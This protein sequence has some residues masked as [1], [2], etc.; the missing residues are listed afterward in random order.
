MSNREIYAQ[1]TFENQATGS[2]FYKEGKLNDPYLGNVNGIFQSWKYS[3]DAGKQVF[4]ATDSDKVYEKRLIKD[5][6]GNPHWGTWVEICPGEANGIQAISINNQPLLLPNEDGAIKLQ[7]TPQMIDTYTKREIYDL[8]NSKVEEIETDAYIYVAWKDGCETPK[9]VLE[10]TFPEGGELSKFYLVDPKPEEGVANSATYFI[11]TEN[12][13]WKEADIPNMGAFVSYSAFIEHAQDKIIHVSAEDREKWDSLA[14]AVAKAIE[15]INAAKDEF[16]LHVNNINNSDSPHITVEERQKLLTAYEN[17]KDMPEED[18]RF[19]I[20]NKQYVRDYIQYDLDPTVKSELLKEINSKTFNDGGAL[21]LL[22][23]NFRTKYNTLSTQ[24]KCIKNLRVELS[25]IMASAGM[26]WHLDANNGWVSDQYTNANT[27]TIIEIPNDKLPE[28]LNIKLSNKEASVTVTNIKI[29]A[30]YNQKTALNVG[31]EAKV[32]PLNLV[33]PEDVLPTYNGQS[34]KEVFNEDTEKARWG[35]ITG[36]PTLQ[37]DLI[38][39]INEAIKNKVE[40][41]DTDSPYR[42][43]V[44]GNGTIRSLIQN[45]D[46]TSE[47]KV[48]VIEIPNGGL[49]ENKIV[50]EGIKAKVKAL[51][52]AGYYVYNAKFVAENVACTNG[53]DGELIPVYFETENIAYDHSPSVCGPFEYNWPSKV[54]FDKIYLK[55]GKVE[56][57]TNAKVELEY[58]AFSDIK[59]GLLNEI[60]HKYYNVILSAEDF[61]V[62]AE[63]ITLEAQKEVV[64]SG[65]ESLSLSAT[66]YEYGAEKE[67]DKV[68]VY[69]EEI[70]ERYASKD[71][72]KER[73]ETDEADITELSARVTE[74]ESKIDATKNE[75]E[76]IAADTAAKVQEIQD[77]VDDEDAKIDSVKDELLEKIT[78]LEEANTAD[79]EDDTDLVQRVTALEE[80]DEELLQEINGIKDEYTKKSELDSLV[81]DLTHEKFDLILTT[82]EDFTAAVKEGRFETAERILFHS[83]DYYFT[84][85]E[86]VS[87]AIDFS[88]I[89][90]IKGEI[91]CKITCADVNQALPTNYDYTVFDGID[92]RIGNLN[93]FEIERTGKRV[94]NVE[95]AGGTLVTI[96]PE[97]DIIKLNVVDDTKITLVSND[98]G[99]EYLVY[100]DQPLEEVKNVKFTNFFTNDNADAELL[101]GLENQRPATRTVL[102]LISDNKTAKDAFIVKQVIYGINEGADTDGL[103]KVVAKNTTCKLHKLTVKEQAVSYSEEEVLGIYKPGTTFTVNPTI[104]DGFAHN[105]ELGYDYKVYSDTD[106]EIGTGLCDEKTTFTVPVTLTSDNTIYVEF[107]IEPQLA[108]FEIDPAYTD[109]VTGLKG[110]TSV[111]TKFGQA[112]LQ[113]NMKQGFY[114][115]GYIKGNDPMYQE[116]LPWEFVPAANKNHKNFTVYVKPAFYAM[117]NDFAM[118]QISTYK[119][120][121]TKVCL[122]GLNEFDIEAA[123]PNKVKEDP[124]YGVLYTQA[125]LTLIEEDGCLYTGYSEMTPNGKDQI[126]NITVDEAALGQMI[127]FKF[128]MPDG[129]EFEKEFYVAKVDQFAIVSEDLE[130]DDEGKYKLDT[131][132]NENRRYTFKADLEASNAVND[133]S[134]EWTVSDSAIASI[135]SIEDN[136]ITIQ[137]KKPG[138]TRLNF[139][140]NFT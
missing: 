3:Y 100:I 12:G 119:F 55:G 123:V 104:L 65:K 57:L 140:S 107:F 37:K 81:G 125:P 82:P 5:A 33:G 2:V 66:E 105:E 98:D 110:F 72:T 1:N 41:P 22:D 78:A 18:G 136:I 134:G 17:M 38:Q 56:Y 70:D 75:I 83:G 15:D 63:N 40:S 133:L 64:I 92:L 117:F 88:N 127:T 62:N 89:K 30:D 101:S 79:E 8:I 111:Q 95:A 116:S 31:D 109:Y 16:F 128:G 77:K 23:E 124:N 4:K 120:D 106:V 71:E 59:I 126:L 67:T 103:I 35:K 34:L 28:A 85:D 68:K 11:Y 131:Y 32:L 54:E 26:S 94:L 102:N 137:A 132:V 86:L 118:T 36:D 13:E 113:F 96:P 90:Y 91:P 61:N 53:A 76:Q 50:V 108:T 60:T 9:E 14:E 47:K 93:P 84:D 99:K 115:Y 139:K 58:V 45:I 44:Y 7:I 10:A 51:R 46:D 129:S 73:F 43:D 21:I 20:E 42:Y 135:D 130:L 6:N 122:T 48:E 87:K 97:Y 121:K 52:D 29:Y 49:K 19:V 69:G 114:A 112:S 25:N 27:Y 138:I 39:K 24:G 74:V 80:T